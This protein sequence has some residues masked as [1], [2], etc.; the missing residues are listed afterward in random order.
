MTLTALTIVGLIGL[1]LFAGLLGALVG[2]GGGVIIIPVL[3]LA[4]GF[5]IKIAVA[6]S[7]VAVVATSTAAGSV[8][9]GKGLTNMRLGMTLEI[10]TTL[11]GI[12]GGLL[13]VFIPS[14]ILAGVFAVMMAITAILM[15]RRAEPKE[16]ESPAAAETPTNDGQPPP[17]SAEGQEDVG[18]LAGSY[19]DPYHRRM[20][21][22]QARRLPIGG[23]VSFTAG[24]VSGMLGVGGGFIKVPAMNLA[25]GVPIKVAAATSNFMIGVT[26]VSSLFVYFARGLVHP[27]V[28]APIALGVMGGALAGTHVAHRVAPRS[29]KVVLAIVLVIVAIQM[30]LKSAGITIGG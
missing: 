12:S 8:Y 6:A 21:H 2:I 28:A 26:A 3:V 29:L 10:A 23:A 27:L 20:V 24:I 4:F 19:H 14:A 17:G 15:L 5:D 1:G 18:R 9:V 30:G 25:M 13:A 11:G 7:L 22:Y 16:R